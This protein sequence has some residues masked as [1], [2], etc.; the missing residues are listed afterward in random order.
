MP[1]SSSA[2]KRSSVRVPMVEP[3]ACQH[4]THLDVAATQRERL[5]TITT[6]IGQTRR[7]VAAV[8]CPFVGGELDLPAHV[9]IAAA[10]RVSLVHHTLALDDINLTRTHDFATR[11]GNVELPP[12]KV[13]EHCAGKAVE[14][15]GERD[16]DVRGEVEVFDTERAVRRLLELKD[17][18]RSV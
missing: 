15:L 5:R 14:C 3:N 1:S 4:S 18:C 17:N 12:V 11:L 10:L 6:D 2:E 8:Q 13:R 9:E 16:A 7:E